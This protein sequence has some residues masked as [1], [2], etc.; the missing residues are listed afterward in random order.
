MRSLCSPD[1]NCQDKKEF[2]SRSLMYAN[3][4]RFLVLLNKAYFDNSEDIKADIEENE[5][6]NLVIAFYQRTF[7][8]TC[9]LKCWHLILYQ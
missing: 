4:I 9:H 5:K 3:L 8:K 2:G 6:I 1:F 7:R